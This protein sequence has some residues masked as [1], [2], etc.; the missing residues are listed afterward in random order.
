MRCL[1]IATTF[2]ACA[3]LAQTPADRSATVTGKVSTADGKPVEHATVLVYE[4]GVK[5]GYS[6]YCPTCWVDCGKHTFTDADGNYQITGLNHDLI[7]TLLVVR[8]GYSAAYV[9][10]VNPE[11][12]PA[13]TAVLKM[14]PPIDDL[15]KVVRGQV[16]DV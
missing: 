12:G 14:R 3:A 11:N 13:K 8:E 15:S 16:V 9:K 5:K 7:F 2:L 6:I 10:K 1:L 4:A